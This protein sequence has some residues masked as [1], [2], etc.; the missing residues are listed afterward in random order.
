MDFVLTATNTYSEYI[1]AF[2][3][4]RE[5]GSRVLPLIDPQNAFSIVM[6][7]SIA[8]LLINKL[9]FTEKEVQQWSQTHEINWLAN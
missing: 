2:L 3:G 7:Y 8:L 9:H 5:D 6:A 1:F 4:N